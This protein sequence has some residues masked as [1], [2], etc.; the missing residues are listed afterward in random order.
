MRIVFVVLW[1]LFCPLSLLAETA[2][3]AEPVFSGLRFGDAPGDSMLCTA[4]PCVTGLVASGH[5]NPG[6]RVAKYKLPVDSTHVSG[7]EISSP[8]YFFHQ[9]RLFQVAFR[10]V[11]EP[12][13]AEHCMAELT[14]AFDKR[15][16]MRPISQVFDASSAGDSSLQLNYFMAGGYR[17]EILR[18][19][20]EGQW[21]QPL[22]S[23]YHPALMDAVRLAANPDYH[24]DDD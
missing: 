8:G 19:Q 2:P 7:V 20:V 1:F 15:Y 5:R 22:V 10:I 4:G 6:Q 18:S 14:A 17:V 3:V 16:G 12:E 13:K 23:L 9:N 11:C 21:L 24:S